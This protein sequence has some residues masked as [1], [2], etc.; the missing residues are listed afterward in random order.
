MSEALLNLIAESEALK[1]SLGNVTLLTEARN[2]SLCNLD[3]GTEQLK[4]RKSLLKL[5]HE[6]TDMPDLEVS[7]DRFLAESWIGDGITK[8]ASRRAE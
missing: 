6:I 4:L 3:F 1:H 5:N 7:L 8:S 2:P